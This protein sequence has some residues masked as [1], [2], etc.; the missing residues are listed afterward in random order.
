MVSNLQDYPRVTITNK[1]PYDADDS[2][3]EFGAIVYFNSCGHNCS[4]Y[5][6]YVH[7]KDIAPGRTWT[8][9]PRRGHYRH[10]LV[11]YIE[12]SLLGV[13]VCDSYN[14]GSKGTSSSGFNILMNGRG[15]CCV[16]PS[17]AP[18]KCP[19]TSCYKCVSGENCCFVTQGPWDYSC[20]HCEGSF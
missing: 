7:K 5:P 11:G 6:D 19:Q 12:A 14:S 10:C 1:T 17:D 8:S 20:P 2:Q 3:L 15:G 4:C 18:Q 13:G 16:L 9:D